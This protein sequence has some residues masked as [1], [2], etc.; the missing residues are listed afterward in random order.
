[1]VLLYIGVAIWGLGHLIQAL[2]PGLRVK[3][4]G[5]IGEGAYKG[6]FALAMVGSIVLMVFGWRAAEPVQIYDAPS[7]GR[8]AGMLIIVIGFIF[9]AGARMKTNLKRFVRHPQLTGFGLWA[10]GHLLANGDSRSL[11]LFGAMLV[12]AVVEIWAINRRD[13]K[14]EKLVKMPLKGDVIPVVIGG[15]MVAVLLFVHPYISGVSLISM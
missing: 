12:W 5:M 6:M 2:L 8:H 7:W 9:M 10:V 13:P 1:M 14:P 4:M 11:V 3:L 15:V